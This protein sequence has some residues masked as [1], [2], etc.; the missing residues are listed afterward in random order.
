M[1]NGSTL[2]FGE[3]SDIGRRRTSN[4]DSLAVAPPAS[5]QQFRTRGWLFLVA[6]GMGAH[7]AGERASR[8]AAEHVPLV[9]EKNASRSPPLALLRGLEQANSEINLRGR[10]QP[11]YMGMGTTCTTLVI[12]PRGALVGHVGDSRAYRLRGTRLEQLTRDHSAVWELESQGGL[13]R[14]QAERA[15]GKNVITRSMGPHERVEVDVEGPLPVEPGDVFL[16]CSDGLSGQVADEEIG[17]FMK[18]LPPRDACQALVGLTLVRGAPDNVT[19]IV[20]KAGSEEASAAGPGE[21]PWALDED[22]SPSGP[23]PLPW[24]KLSVAA[25]SLLVALVLSPWSDLAQRLPDL[26]RA[27]STVASAAALLVALFTVILAFLGFAL[28]R[29]TGASL[30]AGRRLGAGP[31]R[32]Y[33]CTAR[34][35]LLDGI[36]SSAESAADGLAPAE[37]AKMLAAAALARKYAAAG[38]FHEATRQAAE[39]IGVYARSVEEARHGETIR[40]P[41]PRPEDRGAV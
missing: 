26:P 22:W 8:M 7:V 25:I 1:G 38:S 21:A 14:E 33:D 11:E 17:L 20:A 31:Y 10:Q 27:V 15:V 2:V 16:L 34:A 19:V 29:G 41:A 37:S 28:P 13:S 3:R 12:L 6:D 30:P 23:P 36:V 5:P 39:A 4:Q 32:S 18:E 35:S 9:Y 40:I 24:R